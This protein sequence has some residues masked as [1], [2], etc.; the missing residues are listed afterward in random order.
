MST[1]TNKSTGAILQQH[2]Y[3]GRFPV[4]VLERIFRHLHD[5][6]RIEDS[7]QVA[8]HYWAQ[9]PEPAILI[10]KWP[11]F[12]ETD[13]AHLSVFPYCIAYVCSTWNEICLKIPEFWTRIFVDVG[14]QASSVLQLRRQ[15]EATKDSGISLQL[16]ISRRDGFSTTDTLECR[17]IAAFLRVLDHHFPRCTFIHI[18]TMHQSWFSLLRKSLVGSAPLLKYLHVDANQQDLGQPSSEKMF[19]RL[20][21]PGIGHIKLHSYFFRHLLP[22]RWISLHSSQQLNS[23]T[24]LDT[25]QSDGNNEIRLQPMKTFRAINAICGSKLRSLSLVGIRFEPSTLQKVTSHTYGAIF[26]FFEGLRE[27]TLENLQPCAAA[28]LMRL[29]RENIFSPLAKLVIKNCSI[30]DVDLDCVPAT[31]YLRLEDLTEDLEPILLGSHAWSWDIRNCPSFTSLTIDWMSEDSEITNWAC[32]MLTHLI[33]Y[34]E[35]ISNYISMAV[36]KN[37]V[38][39]R[40]KTFDTLPVDD[41]LRRERAKLQFLYLSG[42]KDINIADREWLNSNIDC[43]IVDDASIM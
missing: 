31:A 19:G 29:T 6:N 40:R 33:I 7:P 1:M 38:D 41:Q 42:F 17:R 4:E 43:V 34:G 13:M 36:I 15:L 39:I 8:L 18:H 25:P 30:S 27:L 28:V 23:L 16:Y 22:H 5:L 21:V 12:S 14:P 24:V 3:P 10:P 9:A 20:Y 11:R 32:P 37:M 26:R 35:N 2:F